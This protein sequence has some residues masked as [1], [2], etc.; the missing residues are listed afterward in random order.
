[1]PDFL[2]PPKGSALDA[3]TV[4]AEERSRESM[5]DGVAD[6]QEWSAILCV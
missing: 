2:T 6:R 5:N 4:E 1:M 3:P